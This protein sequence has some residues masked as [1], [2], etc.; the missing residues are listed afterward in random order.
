MDIQFRTATQQ[1]VNL[2]A[3]WTLALHQHEK[4]TTYHPEIE[5]E[6]SGDFNQQVNTWLAGL[7][8]HERTLM[9]LAEIAQQP[10]GM[11]F[12]YIASQPNQ[13]TPYPC[14]GVIQTV[15]VEPDYRRQGI[16]DKLVRGMETCMHDNNVPYIEIQFLPGNQHAEA[17][18]Q[19]QGYLPA[20][21]TSRKFIKS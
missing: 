12:G 7:I 10:V 21:I 20:H 19:R 9:M 17:F 4:S 14:H 2:L 13:F 11:I 8:D 15:W 6:V 1:D 3:R 16:A 5:L 18:W